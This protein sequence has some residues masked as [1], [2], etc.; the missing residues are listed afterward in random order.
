MITNEEIQTLLPIDVQRTI[1]IWDGTQYRNPKFVAK[2]RFDLEMIN[3]ATIDDIGIPGLRER[4]FN[5]LPYSIIE[6]IKQ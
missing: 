2:I 6:I 1:H 4:L 3:E 5:D